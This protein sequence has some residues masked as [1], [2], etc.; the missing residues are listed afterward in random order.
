MN[1]RFL[2]TLTPISWIVNGNRHECTLTRPPHVAS[3][4]PLG[5]QYQ[6]NQS[7]PCKKRCGCFHQTTVPEKILMRGNWAGNTTRLPATGSSVH[8]RLNVNVGSKK[9]AKLK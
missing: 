7:Y 2:G 5:L 3:A 9:E 8:A 6:K 1:T 4:S